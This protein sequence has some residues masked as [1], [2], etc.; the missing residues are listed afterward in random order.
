MVAPHLLHLPQEVLDLVYTHVFPVTRH[1]PPSTRQAE[2]QIYSRHVLIRRTSPVPPSRWK[3]CRK[4]MR[5]CKKCYH[6]V[7]VLLY[8]DMFFDVRIMGEDH[9][10][11]ALALRSRLESIYPLGPV[12]RCPPLQ[13]IRAIHLDLSAVQRPAELR[14]LSVR[15][16]GFLDTVSG[17]ERLTVKSIS[18]N[19][20]SW[21]G[22]LSAAPPD[23]L[24][25]AE[26][27]RVDGV[28]RVL[29]GLRCNGKV[30]LYN[31]NQAVPEECLQQLLSSMRGEQP[32][33]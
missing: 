9:E 32:G 29:R 19:V 14:R 10:P 1:D 17:N 31:R 2:L 26:H 16:R 8:G 5:T 18:F 4:L 33:D 12:G 21:Q 3:G 13:Y 11:S 6:D 24:P 22:V 28:A 25:E 27:C 7:L 30:R 15:L 23:R 20:P